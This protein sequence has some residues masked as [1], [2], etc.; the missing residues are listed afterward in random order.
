MTIVSGI[1]TTL[2]VMLREHPTELENLSERKWDRK[3]EA[4]GVIADNLTQLHRWCY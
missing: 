1:V 4:G 2:V 3:V